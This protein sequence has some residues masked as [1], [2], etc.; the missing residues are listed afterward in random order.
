MGNVS[1]KM[2]TEEV[3]QVRSQPRPRYGHPGTMPT[4]PHGG[5]RLPGWNG[6]MAPVSSGFTSWEEHVGK[7][8]GCF[9]Y[10][11]FLS[12]LSD[13]MPLNHQLKST[14]NHLTLS[15]SW[16]TALPLRQLLQGCIQCGSSGWR[17]SP[18]G[19]PDARGGSWCQAI[20][21]TNCRNSDICHQSMS[22]S[23]S[24]SGVLHH[25]N[26]TI[27]HHITF[28]LC[29]LMWSV[30]CED[31]WC[32]M[33][34]D[35]PVGLLECWD[36]RRRFPWRPRMLCWRQSPGATKRLRLHYHLDP[37]GWFI[38]IHS[39]CVGLN[40]LVFFWSNPKFI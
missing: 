20:G 39:S 37:F 9:R 7:M 2:K 26:R 22:N 15:V 30:M 8:L 16:T 6:R 31:V 29:E 14:H 34:Q 10:L 4:S 5:W 17:D 21:H 24:K 3:K 13:A 12:Y 32:F 25:L 36:G 1:K 23:W 40:S 19:A 33:W 11:H 38:H 28:G 35:L 27:L 18:P